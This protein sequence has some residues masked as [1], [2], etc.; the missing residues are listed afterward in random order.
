MLTP[1]STRQETAADVTTSEGT[2]REVRREA[3]F[4][5]VMEVPHN[6][7]YAFLLDVGQKMA[8][9]CHGNRRQS[10]HDFSNF[11]LPPTAS[12]FGDLSAGRHTVRIIGQQDDLPVLFWRPSEDRTVLRSPVA[13]AIDYVVFAGPTSDDV[14]ARL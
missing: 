10:G 2:R 11:W 12:W 14:I 4:S 5:G 1:S 9:R 3:E 6:G 8:R 13:D 7:R